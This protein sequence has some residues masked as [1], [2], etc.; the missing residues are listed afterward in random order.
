MLFPPVFAVEDEFSHVDFGGLVACTMFAAI[1]K[2]SRCG[3]LV[4]MDG[5]SAIDLEK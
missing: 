2:S 4:R 3:R 5:G 1:W